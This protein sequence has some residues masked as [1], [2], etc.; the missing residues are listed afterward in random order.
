MNSLSYESNNVLNNFIQNI[1]PIITIFIMSFYNINNQFLSMQVSALIISFFALFRLPYV[2]NFVITKPLN[3]IKSFMYIKKNNNNENIVYIPQYI[4]AYLNNI[5]VWNTTLFVQNVEYTNFLKYIKLKK[6][7][8]SKYSYVEKADTKNH[9]SSLQP[10]N[11][12]LI[13]VS[14]MFPNIVEHS[15]IIDIFENIKVHIELKTS[16]ENLSKEKINFV[17]HEEMIQHVSHIKLTFD[18]NDKDISKKYCKYVS[19]YVHKEKENLIYIITS[20]NNNSVNPLCVKNS[21]LDSDNLLT[22]SQQP[23]NNSSFVMTENKL[24]STKSKKTLV[25]S[26]EVK[27]KLYNEID[28][29]MNNKEYYKTRGIPYTRGYLLYGPPGTGKTSIIKVIAKEYNI[30]IF[31][32]NI[33]MCITNNDLN[34]VFELIRE[35]S[36]NYSNYIIALED[37]DKSS[38]YTKGNLSFDSF[39]NILDGIIEDTGRILFITCNDELNVIN[40]KTLCRPGRIDSLIKIDYACNQQIEDMI[41]IIYS[42]PKIKFTEDNRIIPITPATVQEICLNNINNVNKAIY[43]IRQHITD[44]SPDIITSNYDNY[45]YYDN[46][47]RYDPFD[48]IDIKIE[49]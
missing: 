15:N 43:Q 45:G 4:F 10:V 29:F 33:S 13:S 36:K 11:E 39:Y 27:S 30:P 35:K 34:T 1:A 21:K 40:D 49:K 42:N 23:V 32:T 48:L 2:Y 38:L 9:Y 19:K 17:T 47:Y 31:I 5:N 18:T 26:N 37:F 25:I 44:N 16:R 28:F 24:V 3:Y 14:D 7:Y 20:K 12:D 8:N 46:E 41:K 6:I 22:Q